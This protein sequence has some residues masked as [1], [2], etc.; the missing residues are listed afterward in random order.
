MLVERGVSAD[1]LAYKG[2]AKTKPVQAGNSLT[3][4]HQNKRIEL[5]LFKNRQ[6]L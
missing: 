1:R 2:L 6:S 3:A 5:I 4:H